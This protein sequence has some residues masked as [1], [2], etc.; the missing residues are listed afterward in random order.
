MKG[1]FRFFVVAIFAVILFFGCTVWLSNTVNDGKREKRSAVDVSAPL[2]TAP[3][4]L[5]STSRVLHVVTHTH[6]DREWYLPFESFRWRLTHIVDDVLQRIR[7]STN[8]ST[9]AGQFRHFLLDGTVAP[10]LDYLEVRADPAI[11]EK[12]IRA[13]NSRQ[14]GVGPWFVQPD[15]FLV[16][17]ESLVRNLHLGLSEMSRMGGRSQRIGI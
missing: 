2:P 8:S 11:R 13:T 3:A 7:D 1:C 17:G 6:F 16:G 4:P 14:L 5:S 12:V 10:L 9:A 15:E